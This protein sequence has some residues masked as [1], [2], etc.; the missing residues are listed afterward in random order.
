MSPQ[1]QAQQERST[2]FAL[3]LIRWIALHMG[4]GVA[5][6][7][8]YPIVG[9]F[10]LTSRK[11]RRASKG[12]LTR[13]LGRPARFTDGARHI[14]CFASTILDRVFLLTDRFDEFDLQISGENLVRELGHK[15]QGCL[16]VGSHLGSFEVLRTLGVSKESEG[17][18]IRLLM[19]HGQNQMITNLLEALNP[20]I[21]N[22]M[23]DTSGGDADTALKIKDALDEGCMVT[24][25][26]DR[27]NSAQEKFT[28]CNFLGDQ[29][30]FPLGW[31]KLAAVLKV[32]VV[33]CFGLYRG[34]NRYDIHF[35]LLCDA[36][37][38]DRGNR[39]AEVAQWAQRYA[40][41]LAFHA[42]S[43]PYNWFNFF[44]FWDDKY[45]DQL[46]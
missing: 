19:N 45:V 16:L 38:L 39:D 26:G 10:L 24:I 27:V 2:P 20:D 33:L 7:L 12:Y 11:A 46:D 3:K 9:Y 18:K 5:R 29:A 14:H 4:R 44:D 23:I 40:D 6:L 25:L 41:R 22:I 35:E 8:L 32:P 30:V 42:K 13:V 15:G 34:G 1:W 31:L 37:M 36:L 28:H 21:R 43:A 17:V